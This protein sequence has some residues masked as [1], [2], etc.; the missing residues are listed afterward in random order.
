RLLRPG[1]QSLTRQ[2]PPPAGHGP[3]QTMRNPMWA[4]RCTSRHCGHYLLQERVD[5]PGQA[6]AKPPY[7]LM[8]EPAAQGKRRSED[9]VDV[10][11]HGAMQNVTPLG[12]TALH[13]RYAGEPS[14]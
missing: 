12:L 5:R 10:A 4:G 2:H 3:S 14:V 6:P 13:F 1:P 8:I 7:H 11:C 9:T